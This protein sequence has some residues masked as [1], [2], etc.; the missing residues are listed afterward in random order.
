MSEAAKGQTRQGWSLY[1]HQWSVA[2]HLLLEQ[3]L[4]LCYGP[5]HR[6]TEKLPVIIVTTLKELR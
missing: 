3:G 4:F 6:L 5:L 2:S 1:V